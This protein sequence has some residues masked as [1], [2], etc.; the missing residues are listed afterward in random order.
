LALVITTVI[1]L[2]IQLVAQG[3]LGIDL[4]NHPDAPLAESAAIFLGNLGRM[5]LLAGASI[6]RSD[7]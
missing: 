6:S 7:L 4:G 5:I 2:M 3:T 1:Y